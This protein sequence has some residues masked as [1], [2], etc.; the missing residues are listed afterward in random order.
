MQY[1]SDATN[2]FEFR[3]NIMY[4][5]DLLYSILN[6]REQSAM[7]ERD[8]IRFTKFLDNITNQQLENLHAK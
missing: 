1:F 2:M 5:I 4:F 8:Q 6:W 3:Y 7:L